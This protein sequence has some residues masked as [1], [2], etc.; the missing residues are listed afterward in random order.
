M[1]NAAPQLRFTVH[2]DEILVTLPGY[3]YSVTYYKPQSSPGLLAKN[4][5]SENDLRIA[6]TA[7]EFLAQAWKLANN[8]ARELGW[9]V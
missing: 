4:M 2:G 9:V 8:R 6:M 7:A 3:F 1:T 5:T